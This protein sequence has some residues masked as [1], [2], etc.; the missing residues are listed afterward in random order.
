[1]EKY[2]KQNDR[3]DKLWIDMSNKSKNL[4][5]LFKNRNKLLWILPI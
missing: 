2:Q 3:N 5:R 4:N 1:M